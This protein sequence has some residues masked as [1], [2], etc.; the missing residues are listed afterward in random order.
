MSE[1]RKKLESLQ[2]T[3]VRSKKVVD[4]ETGVVLGEQHYHRDGSVGATVLAGHKISPLVNQT[5]PRKLTDEEYAQANRVHSELLGPST[6]KDWD[7][8]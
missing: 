3:K 2:F 1:F 6:T 8:G 7:D 4:K 5:M